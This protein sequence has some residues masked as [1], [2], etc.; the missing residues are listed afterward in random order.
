MTAHG[1][2]AELHLHLYGSIRA[3]DYLEHVANR[4]VDWGF[5]ERGYEDAYGEHPPVREILERHRRGDPRASGDFK[6]LFVFGDEDGGNFG[7]FQAKFNLL[8]NGSAFLE[9]ERHADP[10]PPLLREVEFFLERMLAD[11]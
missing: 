7:R 8:I 4:E 3:G 5:Y 9:M 11:Q 2:T 10:I 1:T 6:R